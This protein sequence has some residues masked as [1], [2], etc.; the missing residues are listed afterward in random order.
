MPAPSTSS[1]AGWTPG[2]SR[3]NAPRVRALVCAVSLAACGGHDHAVPADAEVDAPLPPAATGMIDTSFGTGGIVT[4][5]DSGQLVASDL[6]LRGDGYVVAGSR[7]GMIEIDALTATGQ[8]DTAWA[9]SGR[10]LLAGMYGDT[11]CAIASHGTSVLVAGTIA[12]TDSD[13]QLAMLAS[14]GSPAASFGDAGYATFDVYGAD[15]AGRLRFAG[16]RSISCVSI[17]TTA[18]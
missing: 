14:D 10:L 1:F 2:C 6:A 11:P 5:G 12:R 3:G 9:T 4:L 17:G 8:L 15:I 7:A 13:L 18:P 16:E